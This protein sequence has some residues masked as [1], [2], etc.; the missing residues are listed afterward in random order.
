[1][2]FDGMEV[3]A[4]SHDGQ[5]LS[6]AVCFL[7]RRRNNAAGQDPTVANGGFGV[8]RL[9]TVANSFAASKSTKTAPVPMRRT[10]GKG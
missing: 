9:T 8:S 7:G 1:M 4:W 6:L 2:R 5:Q 10:P 3:Q